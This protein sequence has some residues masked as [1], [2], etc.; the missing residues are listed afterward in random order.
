MRKIAC[1][2]ARIWFKVLMTNSTGLDARGL[3]RGSVDRLNGT[4]FGLASQVIPGI[5]NELNA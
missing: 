5:F 1:I 2:R 4:S 3:R